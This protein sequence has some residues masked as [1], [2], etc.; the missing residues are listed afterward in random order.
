MH[1][2]GVS[3]EGATGE[4]LAHQQA[5]RPP[6]LTGTARGV[7]SG[8]G[9]MKGLLSATCSGDSRRWD[10]PSAPKGACG[11]EFVCGRPAGAVIIGAQVHSGRLDAPSAV[12]APAAEM[13]TPEHRPST[14][15]VCATSVRVRCRIRGVGMGSDGGSPVA[16]LCR[17]HWGRHGGMD[18]VACH[19]GDSVVGGA[20]LTGYGSRL[21]GRTDLGWNATALTHR[22]GSTRTGP[23]RTSR[24][25]HLWHSTSDKKSESEGVGWC[26]AVS[27]KCSLT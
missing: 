22:T 14:E 12:P 25:G 10:E 7:C 17:T 27:I 23:H 4:T 1:S 3:G 2:P 6:P 16:S 21:T 5:G 11:G 24:T 15:C 26:Q 18:G 8:P 20:P 19:N 9:S 13:N